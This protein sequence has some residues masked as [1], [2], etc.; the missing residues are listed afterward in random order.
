[1]NYNSSLEIFMN[2]PA[3]QMHIHTLRGRILETL[4]SIRFFIFQYGIVYKLNL[5]GNNTSLAVTHLVL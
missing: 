3:L 2:C 5:T 1:M 4:L